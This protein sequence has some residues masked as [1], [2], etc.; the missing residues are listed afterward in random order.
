VEQLSMLLLL[1]MLPL[2]QN[3]VLS[4]VRQLK[5]LTRNLLKY[6]Q[7][8][9]NNLFQKGKSSRN[10]SDSGDSL[11]PVEYA[12]ANNAVS[13]T[14]YAHVTKL[15]HFWAASFKCFPYRKLLNKHQIQSFRIVM[16]PNKQNL[17]EKKIWP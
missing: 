14:H 6:I 16:M 17:N 12:A 10:Q 4:N 3:V 13:K 2:R 9:Q 5:R 7:S 1:T 11:V 15:E 8:Y